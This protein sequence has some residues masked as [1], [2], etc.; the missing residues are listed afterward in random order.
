MSNFGI[1]SLSIDRNKP[2]KNL[3]V[4]YYASVAAVDTPSQRIRKPKFTNLVLFFDLVFVFT[5]TQV[6]HLVI[7]V[8]SVLDVFKALFVLTVTWWMYG[9]YAWLENNI[10]TDRFFI[11]C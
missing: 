5:I 4:T 3:A 2:N 6:T 10:G 9:G 11:G 8:N 7:D 1:V